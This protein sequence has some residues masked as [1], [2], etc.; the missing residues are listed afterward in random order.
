MNRYTCQANEKKKNKLSPQYQIARHCDGWVPVE[1]PPVV[2]RGP[3]HPVK[4]ER[5]SWD[6]S[7]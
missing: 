5:V 2:S 3:A 4:M 7:C 1:G 6:V